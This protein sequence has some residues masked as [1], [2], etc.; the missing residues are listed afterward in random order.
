MIF[1]KAYGRIP[2]RRDYTLKRALR[3]N[4]DV[5]LRRTPFGGGGCIVSPKRSEKS[6]I[7]VRGKLQENK[8]EG[9]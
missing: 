3:F 1:T 2:N 5:F 8:K 9:Y 4:K 7:I 6:P